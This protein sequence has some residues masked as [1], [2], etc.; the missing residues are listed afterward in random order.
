MLGLIMFACERGGRTPYAFSR[1]GGVTTTTLWTP[2]GGE[3]ECEMSDGF[4]FE[5]HWFSKFSRCLDPVAGEEVRNQSRQ[6][7][8]ALLSLPSGPRRSQDLG[9]PLVDLLWGRLL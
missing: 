4:G 8:A 1:A 3:E 9:D 5:R 6:T 7:T 2:V